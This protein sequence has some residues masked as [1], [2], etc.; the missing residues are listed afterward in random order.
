[1]SLPSLPPSG[2]AV[3]NN[4]SRNGFRVVSVSDVDASKCQKYEGKV[5]N[6]RKTNREVAEDSDIVI[7]SNGP[8]VGSR[9]FFSYPPT[10]PL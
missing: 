9:Y 1:M 2:D 5:P 4:L 7:T 3:F 10:H 8:L 6:I